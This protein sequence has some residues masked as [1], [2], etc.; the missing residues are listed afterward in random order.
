MFREIDRC[1]LC[2]NTTLTDIV[3]LGEQALTGVF[4]RPS[5]PPLPRGPLEL[6]RCAPGDGR[7]GCGLVQLRHSTDTGLMFG[8]H[9]GYRSSLNASMSRH[10]HAKAAGL[11]QAA[12]LE[13]GDCVLD[14]G[15][16]DGTLLSGYDVPGLVRIGIDPAAER[17]AAGYPADAVRVPDF[18]GA[19][20]FRR[21]SGGR[22]ARL[23]TSIAMF[24]DLESPLDFA[25]QVAEILADDGLWH[26]EQSYLPTMVEQLAYDTICHEHLEYY[27]LGQIEWIARETGLRIVDV[28][29]NLVNGGS[30]AVTLAR[31]GAAADRPG[32]AERSAEVES[33]LA[34]ERREVAEDSGYFPRF[35]EAVRRHR[36]DLR[37]TILELKSRGTVLAGYGASTKGNV[38]LQ[39]VGLSPDD[40]E[41]VAEVNADK[42]GRVTP[43][44]RI[45]IVSESEARARKP[46]CLLVLPWHFREGIVQREREYL[47]SGGSLL[48]PLPRIEVVRA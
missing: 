28:S 35:A 9:Y 6:V 7:A 43:G 12:R 40:L 24:Y 48:F 23:V 3:R 38:L 1:R 21:A 2:G 4:P 32:A 46:G 37:R 33:I 27:A 26:L 10:L 16:N 25:R 15:S 14:I 11:Q 31:S 41:F 20:S 47:A 19:E 39:Y 44:T 34:R 29:F 13:H 17:F 8:D 22:R 45:P 42:Y 30:F 36:D 5:D 18:F